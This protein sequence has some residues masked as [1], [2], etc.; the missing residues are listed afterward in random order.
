MKVLSLLA[1]A[2]LLFANTAAAK[3]AKEPWYAKT[4]AALTDAGYVDAGNKL[5]PAEPTSRGAFVELT[6]K[7]LGGTVR[8][9]FTDAV[10]DDIGLESPWFVIFQEGARGA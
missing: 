8:V 10:F 7:L 5:P 1:T 3:T 2:A 4:V 6:L 9:P